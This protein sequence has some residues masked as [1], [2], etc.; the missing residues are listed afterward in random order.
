MCIRASTLTGGQFLDLLEAA[1]TDI[2]AAPAGRFR[3]GGM[4]WALIRLM[5]IFVPTLKAVAEMSYLWR[6]PHALDGARLATR[7]SALPATPPRQALAQ[8]LRDLG[9]GDLASAH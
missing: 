7:V 1:A 2:G 4:P 6:V 5:G 8:A 9:F 3:R